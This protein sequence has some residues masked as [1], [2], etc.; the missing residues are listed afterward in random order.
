MASVTITKE[1]TSKNM[2]CVQ[3]GLEQNKRR[4]LLGQKSKNSKGLDQG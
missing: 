1:V 3:I 4:A 2:T